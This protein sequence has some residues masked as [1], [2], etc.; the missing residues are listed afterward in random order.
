MISHFPIR[1]GLSKITMEDIRHLT[2]HVATD[3][4]STAERMAFH[5]T[6][7]VGQHVLPLSNSDKGRL[8]TVCIYDGLVHGGV[9]PE[10][11]R[12]NVRAS[13]RHHDDIDIRITPVSASHDYVCLYLKTSLRE[14]WKQVDRDA[15]I[16][17]DFYGNDIATVCLT[18][19]E[20]GVN[21]YSR[22]VVEVERLREKFREWERW[23]RGGLHYIPLCDSERIQQLFT[24]LWGE[25]VSL[26]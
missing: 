10:R 8:F 9:A 11:M 26:G 24:L 2:H 21:G 20:G 3:D 12:L 18:Y 23:S 5:Y 6:T 25:K 15:R 19:S 4:L 7:L 14:R 17:R 13:E 16:A 1:F 22:D